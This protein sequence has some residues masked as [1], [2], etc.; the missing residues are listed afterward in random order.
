MALEDEGR[1]NIL[2][3]RVSKL[4]KEGYRGFTLKNIKKKWDGVSLTVINS[5]GRTFM[6]SGETPEEAGKKII[7]KIDTLLD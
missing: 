4:E 3:E 7:D 6:E 1:D 5:D 2:H